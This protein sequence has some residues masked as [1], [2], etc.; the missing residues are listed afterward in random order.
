[1]KIIKEIEDLKYNVDWY[2]NQ[3]AHTK[4]VIQEY[5]RLLKTSKKRLSKAQKRLK[6]LKAEELRSTHPLTEK[7]LEN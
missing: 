5:K 7:R 3:V 4:K 6:G 1:M 2:E